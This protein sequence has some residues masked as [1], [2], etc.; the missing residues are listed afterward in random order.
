MSARRR[1]IALFVSMAMALTLIPAIGAS[2]DAHGAI[3]IN[4][5]MQNPSAVSDSNG[6]WFELYNSTSNA[7]DIDGWTIADNDFD[8]HVINNGGPL[9]VPADGYLVL[10][11]NSNSGTNGGVTVGYNYG[12]SFFLANGADELVLTDG[13]SIEIDRVEW[14]NGVTFPDPNGASMSLSD[15]T[16]DNNVGAN[17]CT[18]GTLF[19]AGD[20]GTPGATN[21]CSPPSPAVPVLI[22]EIQGTGAT[23]PLVGVEVIVEGVVV[24]DFQDDVGS[25]GDL[26]GFFIQ[27]ED[28]QA[29]GDSLT[30]EGIFVFEGSDP[31]VDVAVG[32][33]VEV[34]ATVAEFST[35]GGASLETQLTSPVVVNKGTAPLP[36]AAVVTL[37]FA[38]IDAPEAFEGMLVRLPQDLAIVEYFNYDRFVE[39]V[40]APDRLFQPTGVFAPGSAEAIALA[41]LNAR[42]VITLDDGLTVQN[43]EVTRHPN[44]DPFS[45]SNR[46]RGGDLVTDTVGVVSNTF[47]LYRIQPTDAANYTAVNDRPPAPQ[48]VGGSLEVASFNVLNYFLTLDEG[49]SRNTCGPDGTQGC[50]G[51]DN[52]EEFDRQRAKILEALAGLD[53]DVVGLIE[54]ENSTG[55][56]P[57]ADIV[58]GLNDIFG[59]GSYDYIDTGTIGTDAIKVGFIYR[60]AAA[61]PLGNFAILDSSV[62]PSFDDTK[63]RPVLAQ[64]FLDRSGG[65]VVT[66][67]VNHL[68]SKG[69]SCADVGDPTDPN[70]QGN[71]NGVRTNAAVALANWLASDPTNSGQSDILIVGDLNAYDKE[72]PITALTDASYTDLVAQ[73]GGEFAYSFLFSGQLGY[74]DHALANDSLASQVTGTSVWQINADEPDL[75]DYDTSFKSDGQDAIFAEDAF[76]A[77]D[78]D[79]VLVGLDL[80]ADI[81]SIFAALVDE[82]AGL[83]ADGALNRGQANALTRHLESAQRQLDRGQSQSAIPIVN[84]FITQV[85]NFVGAD[86][87][88]AD[89]GGSL[90][91]KAEVLQR[92]L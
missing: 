19:G 56:S 72:D 73:F 66:V 63:N 38:A 14:D 71:C 51:A 60:P 8:S 81:A 44:G 2:A 18:A 35:S 32:D 64:S 40:L 79:P 68:K 67:A 77:S 75:L 11:N 36:T 70:G 78:H 6:E 27:E 13:A 26:N 85:N 91:D 45:L 20:L 12:T 30:S 54:M 28:V 53:A 80:D 50:R 43:P 55:V 16:L 69:S 42:S 88:M 57:L 39:I 84:A 76:R 41:D 90:T 92:N 1:I 47:G 49:A 59:A 23:S 7:I 31:L 52:A 37:P 82:V 87:L 48:P 65:G 29:D 86:I 17:W 74:L 22:H 24:G 3:V 58:A 83:K 34:T 25:D 89:Q 46:F 4:E 61:L 5:I 9:L 33:L 15:P 62:D 21:D 10:G